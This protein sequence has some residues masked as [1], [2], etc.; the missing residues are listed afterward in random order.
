MKASRRALLGG[1]LCRP[2]GASSTPKVWH[3]GVSDP[4]L[5]PRVAFGGPLPGVAHAP[6]L[7]PDRP[8]RLGPSCGRLS[9]HRGGPPG[10]PS[11]A[12][13]NRHVLG[14][15]AYHLSSERNEP[16]L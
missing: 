8:V 14:R 10:A 3:R 2:E 5:G 4:R 11:H 7:C 1:G 12:G 9:V 16:W 13:T 6:M 15:A